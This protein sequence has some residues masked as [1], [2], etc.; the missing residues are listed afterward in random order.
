[1]YVRTYVRM[2]P[3]LPILNAM[4][5]EV[6]PYRTVGKREEERKKDVEPPTPTLHRRRVLLGAGNGIIAFRSHANGCRSNTSLLALTRVFRLRYSWEIP[7][8]RPYQ[9][10]IALRLASLAPLTPLTRSASYVA[11]GAYSTGRA[12][13]AL[14]LSL[15]VVSRRER[16]CPHGN[17]PGIGSG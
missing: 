1:M 3:T 14:R 13:G 11:G 10:F 4:L 5:K 16:R 2:Y 8:P 7:L 15:P 6:V 9:R 17:R 12:A